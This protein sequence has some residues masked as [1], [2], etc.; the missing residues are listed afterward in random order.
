MRIATFNLGGA[1]VPGKRSLIQQERSWHWL[2]THAVDLGFIQEEEHAVIPEWV[3]ERWS[4]VRGQVGQWGSAIVADPSLNLRARNDLVAADPWL[5]LLYDYV[6]VGEVDLPDGASALVAS[7]HAVAQTVSDFLLKGAPRPVPA[8]FTEDDLVRIAQPGDVAWILDVAFHAL[9][10]SFEGRRFIVGGD[11]NNARLF[12]EGSVGE[13][14]AAMFFSRAE[15]YGWMEC[16]KGPEQRTFLRPNTRP[17]QLDHLFADRATASKV[18][19]CYAANGWP[20]EELSD[21][22]PLVADLAWPSSKFAEIM[23][24]ASDEVRE[25]DARLVRL[26][27][28]LNLEVGFTRASRQL[29]TKDGIPLL[30]LP[31]TFEQVVLSLATMR[32]VGMESEA[33]QIQQALRRISSRNV[34]AIKPSITCVDVLANWKIFVN[35]ILPRYIEFRVESERRDAPI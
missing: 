9:A 17:F 13:P 30:R 4:V 25:V 33:N 12:D 34:S 2:A 27:E 21:H 3:T 22:A 11:W 20:A 29:R 32:K 35:E 10:R 7:V 14:V 6:V 8:V 31:P 19:S 24:T 1:N 28:E 23:A 16:H 26:A 18:T 15:S 5:T